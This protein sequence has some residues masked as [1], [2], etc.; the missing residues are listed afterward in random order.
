MNYGTLLLHRLRGVLVTAFTTALVCTAIVSP[1]FAEPPRVLKPD[2]AAAI[3]EVDEP[4]LS[5]DGNLI[6][7]VVKTMDLAKDK[8]AKNLW[9]VKWDGSENRA[10]T[11][12]ENK[13]SHPRWSPNGKWLAFLSSRLDENEND[14]LWIM[15]TGGGEAERLTEAKGGID[16]FAWAPDSKRIALV[17]HDPDPRDAVAKEKEK[18]T[19]LPL[20]IDRLFFK[21]D[22][23]G[24]LTERYS[25]LNLL[26][27]ATRKIEPLTAG[28]HDD[29]WPAWSP[30]GSEIAFVTKRGDDPDRTDNWDVYVIAARPGAKERQLTTSP[31][32]DP[33]PDWE[34]APAWSPDGKSIAYIHGGAPKKI[35]YAVHALAVIPAGGGEAR[36]LTEKLDRNVVQP[37]WSADG[38]S[39]FI[40]LE[41]DGGASVARVPL[42]GGAPEIVAGGRRTTTAYDVAPAGKIIV[43]TST[44][45]RPYE[46]F[47]AETGGLRCLTKQNDAFMARVRLGR[48]EET[49]FKSADGTEVHGFVVRPVEETPGRKNAG[50]LR[51]HGGPQSQHANEFNFEAQLFAAN[52]YLVILPNP[53]GGTGRGTD[54]AMGIYADWGHRD[55]EDDLAAVDDAIARGLADPDRLGVGGWSYGGI[56]TNYLIA[57]TTRFKAATSGASISNVL[58]GYGTDQYI[59]DYENELGSP[60]NNPDTWTRISYP[61]LHAD[62]IKTPT[63]FLCGE[64]DFNVPLLNTEQMY[65]ALRTRGVPTE[66]VIYPG[67]FHRLTKPSYIIDRYKRYLD[68]YAKWLGT[69]VNEKSGAAR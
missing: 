24:Y 61:F 54:Y 40:V 2:D 43:R 68:W 5:P 26:D 67:Q 69:G 34:S 1:L 39:I 22:I 12:G 11:F 64:N 13:Q 20:V 9:L 51:P 42:A 52:G 37:H 19:V 66:L 35:E 36:V 17:I 7:Y 32:A 38:K 29:L 3:R 25:H 33:N 65:Q 44:P 45:D 48:V 23:E 60:W 59:R 4:Q 6:T 57:T 50:L 63:L 46:I 62:K 55:V 15:A 31:E 28:K 58:A 53:R 27:L 49:K 14:Q 16:D 21:K 41:D 10:L 56:S 47:A 18:K 30:D 8:Q